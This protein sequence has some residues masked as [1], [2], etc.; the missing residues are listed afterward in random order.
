M[1]T[2]CKLEDISTQ[3]QSLT[4]RSPTVIGGHVLAGLVGEATSNYSASHPRA[5]DEST[6]SISPTNVEDVTVGIGNE[7]VVVATFKPVPI[8]SNAFVFVWWRAA[9]HIGKGSSFTYFAS[10]F[11]II[12]DMVGVHYEVDKWYEKRLGQSIRLRGKKI[13]KIWK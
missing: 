7:D 4:S 11:S 9:Y 3:H 6:R 13:K 5:S 12:T 1:Q 10:N 2:K 8:H